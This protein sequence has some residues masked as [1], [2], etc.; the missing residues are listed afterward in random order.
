MDPI[1]K[2]RFL[3]KTF[4][5]DRFS[6]ETIYDRDIYFALFSSISLSSFLMFAI[7]SA[8]FI[9]PFFNKASINASIS[10]I[11]EIASPE[12]P[13]FR[14][15]LFPYPLFTSQSSIL[16]RRPLKTEDGKNVGVGRICKCPKLQRTSGRTRTGDTGIRN[17]K[18]NDFENS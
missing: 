17:P 8:L 4:T 18:K 6:Q 16:L 11:L 14:F 7:T 12:H 15:C 3:T 5:G 10:N 2:S 9:I 1:S 13:Q